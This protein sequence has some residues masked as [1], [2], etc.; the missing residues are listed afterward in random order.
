MPTRAPLDLKTGKYYFSRTAFIENA[1]NDKKWKILDIGNLGDGPI[2]VDVRGISAK[3][4][5]DY[6]GL[7]CNANLAKSMGY[8]KQ[9]VGDVHD[10]REIIPEG[11]F[12]CV[13]MGQVIEHSWYPGTVIRECHRIIKD[14]GFLILDTPNVYSLINILR[15][16]LKYKDTLGLE[17]VELTY[18]ESKDN[19]K[20]YRDSGKE[21]SQPQHKIFFSP[22]MLRQILN[23]HG[24]AIDELA[25]ISKPRNF[26]HG[27]L[28]RLFPQCSDKIGI[29]AKKQSLERIFNK[30]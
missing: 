12:D 2:N 9:F 17:D 7:D 27:I 21:L 15:Y 1:L 20:E 24:F 28:L 4:N 19:F 13:Y 16:S 22:A 6:Y 8:E 18:N 10:M 29:V 25:F 3:N 23:M 26:F 5:C 30:I 11:T 14:D